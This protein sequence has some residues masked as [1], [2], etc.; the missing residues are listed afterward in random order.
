MEV[1]GTV[2]RGVDDMTARACGSWSRHICS[3][4]A[5]GQSLVLILN[6]SYSIPAPNHGMVP[7]TGKGHHRPTSAGIV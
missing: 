7:P 5:E 3:Q 1:E 2:Y 6:S 4:G